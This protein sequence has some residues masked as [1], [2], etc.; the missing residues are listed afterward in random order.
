[1]ANYKDT[2]E[3]MLKLEFNS[4]K[5]ALHWN[6]KETAWTFMGIYQKAHPHWIGWARIKELLN[7]NETYQKLIAEANSKNTPIQLMPNFKLVIAPISEK[8]YSDTQLRYS[9]EGFYEE[10][11]WKPLKCHHIESQK[12]AEEIF[13]FG[14]N[15]GHAPAIRAAQRIIGVKDDGF[16]GE[17][18]LKALNKF[19]TDTFD[20]E[21][22]LQEKAYYNMLVEQNPDFKANIRGW[23]NRAE[24]V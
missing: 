9:V 13:V 7:S 8:A 23:H 5:N 2:F 19:D 15:T 17:I 22:D 12:K 1:M 18:T 3:T 11:F 24:A 6:K 10:M 21:Y 20:K 4:P 14:V 16:I